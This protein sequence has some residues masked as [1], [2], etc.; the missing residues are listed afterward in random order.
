MH[1]VW[2]PF[3]SVALLLRSVAL[4]QAEDGECIGGFVGNSPSLVWATVLSD[5]S[6]KWVIGQQKYSSK[7]ASQRA[8]ES[9]SLN[10]GHFSVFLGTELAA[11]TITIL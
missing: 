7:G 2:A 6:G 8:S 1:E 9:A 3:G 11:K 5:L 4:N 10:G